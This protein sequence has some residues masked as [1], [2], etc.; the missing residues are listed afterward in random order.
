MSF[1][2]IIAVGPAD[3]D[4][5][6]AISDAFVSETVAGIAGLAAGNMVVAIY[7]P[8]IRLTVSGET[9]GIRLD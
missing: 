6:V 1:V 2:E 7:A 5:G 4:N 9:S 8:F 3:A